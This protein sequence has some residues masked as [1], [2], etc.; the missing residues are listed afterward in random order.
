[1]PRR[2]IYKQNRI[3]PGRARMSCVYINK[4]QDREEK[5]MPP[6]HV[7][8]IIK[9][10]KRS[11]GRASRL[12]LEIGKKNNPQTMRPTRV[13][14]PT[15]WFNPS[16]GG[17]RGATWVEDD[18]SPAQ[19]TALQQVASSKQQAASKQQERTIDLQAR[20]YFDRT[21]KPGERPGWIGVGFSEECRCSL[22]RCKN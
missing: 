6:L 13:G 15:L 22:P 3:Q 18:A 21:R 5:T 7:C 1:M 10:G 2:R 17:P 16:G 20:K 8:T 4:V 9:K 19:S 14:G 12:K 11:S